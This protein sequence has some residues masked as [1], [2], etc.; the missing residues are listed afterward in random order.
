[1]YIVT[2]FV[3]KNKQFF[4]IYTLYYTVP[5]GNYSLFKYFFFSKNN[6]VPMHIVIPIAGYKNE[7]VS[8]RAFRNCANERSFL[9]LEQSFEKKIDHK[10]DNKLYFY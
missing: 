4:R 7:M 2:F 5:S 10:L 1:M 6:Y 3:K 9:R 8:S